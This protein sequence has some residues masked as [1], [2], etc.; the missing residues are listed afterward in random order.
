MPQLC[1]YLGTSSTTAATL[2]VFLNLAEKC[3]QMLIDSIPKI[4]NAASCY[5]NT[6]CLAAQVLAAVGKLSKVRLERNV[7]RT[8]RS[9][10]N[11]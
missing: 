7:M 4:K 11:M 6:L 1:E 2:Q 8:P 9:N 3:P 5:P 10:F